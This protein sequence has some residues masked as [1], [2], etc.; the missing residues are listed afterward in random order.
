MAD[1]TLDEA[2]L[3]SWIGISET[4]TDVIDADQARLMQATLDRNPDLRD[5]DPLPP[6]WHWIYFPVATRLGNLGR[7]GHSKLGDFLPP[8]D[9][10]RRMWAGGRF[11]FSQPLRLGEPITRRS[12]IRDIALKTGRSGQLCFVTVRHEF[13]GEDG[14]PR[15]WEDHDIVYREDPA[16]G[17][18]PSEPATPTGGGVWSSTVTPSSVMLFRYSALTFNGHRIHYDRDYCRDIENY[19]GLVF[20]GPLTATLLVDLAIANHRNRVLQSFAF[21]AVAPLF[22][23]APFT[24]KG[25]PAAG[26]PQAVELWAETPDGAPAMTASATFGP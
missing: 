19:P 6:L 17:A 2:A 1:R 14:S 11:T 22:D 4:A 5:G 3:K 7:E 23:I 15:L 26:D 18:K 20:H 21:R 25:K 13:A 16:P 10:P 24:I 8:I 9:L 12:T